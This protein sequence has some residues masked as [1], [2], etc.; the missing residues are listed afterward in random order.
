MRD[1]EVIQTLIPKG[2]ARAEMKVHNTPPC[3]TT[4]SSRSRLM[5]LIA[6]CRLPN[7]WRLRGE[8]VRAR[9]M[10]YSYVEKALCG[11]CKT[12]LWN[13]CILPNNWRLATSD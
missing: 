7:N 2:I 9:Q 11:G 13:S 12:R 6:D 10:Y 5:L 4:S 1:V 8:R 3:F